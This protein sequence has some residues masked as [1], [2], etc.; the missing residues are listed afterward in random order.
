MPTSQWNHSTPIRPLVSTT[1]PHLNM[2]APTWLQTSAFYILSKNSEHPCMHGL[3]LH[4]PA[5]ITTMH[6]SVTARDAWKDGE[7]PS[8]WVPPV[9]TSLFNTCTHL[10][11]LSIIHHSHPLL[12]IAL[13]GISVHLCNG[14]L[15]SHDF[16]F[17]MRSP[18]QY[19]CMKYV[20]IPVSWVSKLQPT[21]FYYVTGGYIHKLHIY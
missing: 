14:E 10:A 19:L 2:V 12:Y 4:R 15:L 18:T 1:A 16:Y 6:Y 17:Q 5:S 7:Y 3:S 9:D 20:G 11:A 21:R 8:Q 13:R